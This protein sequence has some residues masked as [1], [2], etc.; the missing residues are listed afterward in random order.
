MKCLY[1][2]F[3][4]FIIA[5]AFTFSPIEKCG[6]LA[7]PSI[8]VSAHHSCIKRDVLASY[9]EGGANGRGLGAMIAVGAVI[10]NRCM[11]S[12]FPNSIVENGC[13]LGIMPSPDP[14]EMACFAADI[15]ISGKDITGGAVFFF[16]SEQLSQN[17]DRSGYITFSSDG[18]CFSVK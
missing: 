2:I 9:I 4:F 3:I 14:S 10:S 11:D 12:R 6:A 13:E 17:E 5:S 18:L 15:V 16:E 8:S 1:H 7:P